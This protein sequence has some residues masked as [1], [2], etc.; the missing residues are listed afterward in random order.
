[1]SNI[2]PKPWMSPGWTADGQKV[3]TKPH[4]E[5]SSG[6]LTRWR[7]WWPSWVALFNL[8][9]ILLLQCKF[10][11]KLPNGSKGIVKN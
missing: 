5:H 4:L 3:I 7:L 9:V 8:E 10:Q 11:L 2:A 6:E 1:M